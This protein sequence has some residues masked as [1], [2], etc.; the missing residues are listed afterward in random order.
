MLTEII[1][2]RY[3]KQIS[4]CTNEELY[5][6]LLEMVK[7]KAGERAKDTG[8]RKLYYISA[9]FLIGKL[10]SNNL[11]NLGLYDEVDQLLKENNKS[12]S[13]IEEV[14]MEPSLGNGGLG[15]LAACFLDSIATLGLN[16]DGIGLNYHLGLFKQVFEDNKQVETVNP[17]IQK[18]NWLTKTNHSYTVEFKDFSV[19]STLYDIAVTGYENRTN[20]LHL[21]DLDS[22]DDSIVEDG[23]SFDK[24]EIK[25]NLTLFLYPDDSDEKG[26]LL[27]VYQQYFMVSNGAQY[28]LEECEKKGCKLTDLH[29]YAVIQI[30]DTHPTMVIPELIRLLVKKGLTMDE[31]IGT[32]SKTCA[33][34]NHTILAEALEKWPLEYL[35]K[36]APAIV[37]IIKR[38]WINVSAQ[39]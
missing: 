4:D 21:F 35:E 9:E 19:K 6:A 29:E 26:R 3:G 28:I 32:V 8:K 39:N 7:E 13:E 38:N 5:A 36:V 16:G 30:N 14:E 31:A 15:R 33:Y 27:R 17:W 25:K 22:V 24:D 2:K 1:T 10:L 11:I 20:Q 23:I 37:P 34:T 12:L 18:E